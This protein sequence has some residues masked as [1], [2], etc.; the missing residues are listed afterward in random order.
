MTTSPP[1]SVSVVMPAFN[2]EAFVAD[3]VASVLDGP[4]HDLELVVVDDGSTDRTA[5]LVASRADDPRLVLLEQPNRGAHAAL[6][7]G[8]E[9]ARG[10]VVLILDSDDLF[11]PQRIARTVAALAADPGLAMVASWLEVIDDGGTAVGVK[12]GWHTLPPWPPPTSGPLLSALGEPRLAL[13]E[14]NFVA[15]TSNFALRRSLVTEHGLRFAPLRY[16]HD[17]DFLLQ[18]AAIGGLE[19]LPEP[20]V[21]YRVHAANTIREGAATDRGQGAMRFEIMWTVVRHTPTVLAAVGG[22]RRELERRWWRSAPRFGRDD[23][24]AALLAL[25]GPAPQP[26]PAY[27]ALLSP[28]H[29]FRRAAE[30][31][32]RTDRS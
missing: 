16:C 28:D 5:E 27:D 20:L 21:R 24:L 15:T 17:W 3:A 1:P 26:P 19:L 25:R 12:Q 4:W 9:H 14:T 13:L 22:D 18:A 8:L 11:A 23:L 6:N 31:A 29:P 7:R 10:E 32:L 30:T 2:H